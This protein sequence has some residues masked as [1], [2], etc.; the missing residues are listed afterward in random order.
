[1][2]FNQSSFHPLI[3]GNKFTIPYTITLPSF[4]M[5]FT[6]C[7]GMGIDEVE[8]SMHITHIICLL[9]RKLLNTISRRLFKPNS[10]SIP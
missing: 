2:Q 10:Y 5:A 9:L 1:M 6:A 7:Y 8:I 4:K 3:R